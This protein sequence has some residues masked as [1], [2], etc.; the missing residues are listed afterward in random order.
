MYL[1]AE[2]AHETSE[3][4]RLDEQTELEL[5]V[6]MSLQEQEHVQAQA[7]AAAECESESESAETVPELLSES[8]G[9]ESKSEADST[10]SESDS[11]EA[12]SGAESVAVAA[13]AH[14]HSA[15][16]AA[17]IAAAV[18]AESAA[19]AATAHAE[20]AA[21]AAVAQAESAATAAAAHATAAANT[22]AAH[23][24]AAARSVDA[25]LNHQA[26]SVRGTV[27][28]FADHLDGWWPRRPR[29]QQRGPH[30]RDPQPADGQQSRDPQ[31]ADGQQRSHQQRGPQQKG[32]QHRGPQ[33]ADVQQRG[34][35]QADVQQKGP[36]VGLQASHS[37]GPASSGQAS[38]ED[39]GPAV[40]STPASGS[41]RQEEEAE[42]AEAAEAP[43]PAQQ[44]D[45]RASR[46]HS[47]SS[48]DSSFDLTEAPAAA[49]ALP[50]DQF[51][52]LSLLDSDSAVPSFE[53]LHGPQ[54][55]DAD[56]SPFD[57][58][59]E[60]HEGAASSHISIGHADVVMTDPG[61]VVPVI[62]WDATDTDQDVRHDAPRVQNPHMPDRVDFQALTQEQGLANANTSFSFTSLSDSDQQRTQQGLQDAEF[63]SD[64]PVRYLQIDASPFSA[65]MQSESP[66]RYPQLHRPS[67]HRSTADSSHQVNQPASPRTDCR[68]PPSPRTQMHLTA[69][70]S[71]A[72]SLQSSVSGDEAQL[73]GQHQAGDITLAGGSVG[74]PLD[75]STG[76]SAVWSVEAEEAEE[77]VEAAASI[78]V[79]QGLLLSAVHTVARPCSLLTHCPVLSAA[80]PV[81]MLSHK[82]LMLCF[83]SV[84]VFRWLA[85]CMSRLDVTY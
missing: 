25:A 41:A 71:G 22:V 50:I 70:G 26:A 29:P 16:A 68:E 55:L 52:A 10:D 59:S 24:E 64:T 3:G 83:D 72:F 5:A 39:S 74:W 75:A 35:R 42:A 37:S 17:A 61:Q 8:A 31:P 6:F 81:P 18:Q 23:M 20:S 69:L 66:V 48:D 62:P 67:Y 58:H 21:N 76:A 28:S 4:M 1:D 51:A 27:L 36:Q 65:S 7:A 80:G 63:D 44:I 45:P 15:A 60:D 84:Q 12:A 14:A 78:H 77:P 46:V 32:P 57:V 40:L 49:P 34:S 19:A 82:A 79:H 53:D 54:G 9:S 38:V 11:T 13:A 85:V 73:V 2:S 43:S 56:D 30:C 47:V 33:Q